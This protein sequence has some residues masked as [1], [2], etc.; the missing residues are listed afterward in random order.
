MGPVLIFDK[1]T[2]QS[3]NP[4]EAV[5]LDNFYLSNITPL[6]FIETLADLE[7][8][9]R[10]GRTPEAV[11]GNLAY[12]TPDAG[13]WLNAHHTHLLEAELVGGKTIDMR[14]G[15]PA[16][17]RGK[18]VMLGGQTGVIFEE[19]PEIEA[20]RR[21]QRKEFLEIERLMAKRWR[22]AL[23]GVRYEE[24]YHAHQVMFENRGKP[25]SLQEVK[26]LADS[27]IDGFD[28][29]TALRLGLSMVGAPASVSEDALSRWNQ[30]GE[31]SIKA[32]APYFRHVFS[33]EMVFQLGIATDLISRDR[34]SNKIDL[35]YLYYLPFC[36]V[37]ASNDKLHS[38]VVPLFLDSNQTFIEGSELKA[39]L[40]RL[41]QY[42]SS[43]PDEIKDQGVIR[44]AAYPPT[45]GDYLAS[46][47]WD[48]YLPK[49]RE[50]ATKPAMPPPMKPNDPLVAK[51]NQ[52][53]ENPVPVSPDSHFD[54]DAADSMVVTRMVA[55]R[56]GKWKRFPPE[57]DKK[58]Y[59]NS[60]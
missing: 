27:I 2:L 44:F 36:M 34:P 22:R 20:F 14:Y 10:R 5:W 40:G 56:K 58:Y 8:E 31:Q 21:W 15:R 24:I 41:D 47:L 51:I 50:N 54:S 30:A 6:F 42:Y 26:S 25:K 12:K 59:P 53:M 29:E 37:F 16:T 52:L 11:V 60:V 1:S 3:L 49:W 33:V 13:S 4:D 28:G 43:L 57:M 45:D 19:P 17:S 23:S 38:R 32:F 35:A 48:R 9:V 46:R 18:H 55:V 7:K 39:D